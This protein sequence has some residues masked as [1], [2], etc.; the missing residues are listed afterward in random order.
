MHTY[1]AEQ[2]ERLHDWN[3]NVFLLLFKDQ[4]HK[5]EKNVQTQLEA[6]E[7]PHQIEKTEH[8]AG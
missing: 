3:C 1:T 2:T 4:H 8:F 6:T 7:K 5:Q